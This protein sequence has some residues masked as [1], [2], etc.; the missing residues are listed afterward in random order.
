MS[1]QGVVRAAVRVEQHGQRSPPGCQPVGSSTAVGDARTGGS[2]PEPERGRSG[3][4]A[5]CEATLVAA[6]VPRV[7]HAEPRE[8]LV[9][10]RRRDHGDARRR[11]PRRARPALRRHR[12]PSRRPASSG[13][14]WPRSPCRRSVHEQRRSPST[15]TRRTWMPAGRHRRRRRRTARSGPRRPRPSAAARQASRRACPGT[16]STQP[17]RR[18]CSRARVTAPVGRRRRQHQG[19]LLAP[20][21]H[22]QQRPAAPRS[23]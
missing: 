17:G 12:A 21:Q 23:S 14:T 13:H 9:R 8:R 11:R 16:T 3:G 19:A 18:C 4:S 2:H 1:D 5:A 22:L 15:W 6:A 10:R 7:D 20:A